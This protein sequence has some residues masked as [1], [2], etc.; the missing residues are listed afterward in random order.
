MCLV[1]SGV[2]RRASVQYGSNEHDMPYLYG[3]ED[4]LYTFE[5]SFC[6]DQ[7]CPEG[8]EATFN[9]LVLHFKVSNENWKVKACGVQLLEDTEE[10]GRDEDEDDEAGDG[11]SDGV[12]E[13]I[14]DDADKTQGDKSRRDDDAET[15]SKKRMRFSLL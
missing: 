5:D 11:D 3:W 1:D 13:D 15:R 4:R 6:L 9:K 2:N 14:K 8:E 7:D 12:E 10:S